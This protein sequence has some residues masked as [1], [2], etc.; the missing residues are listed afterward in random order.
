MTTSIPSLPPH[1]G[2][3]IPQLGL[4]T[5][6][7]DDA[8]VE[9][10][11]VAAAG[12]GYRHVD[13]AAKYG[14]EAA[15][16]AGV[17]PAGSPREEWFVTTKL[18]GGYQG[19]D[20]AVA[21]LD[22]SLER[23]GLD[24]VDLLLI[25]WPLPAARPVR[26]D[27]GDVHPAARGGQGSRDRGLQLQA[28]P[29]RPTD[30]RDRR[31][32]GRQPDPAQPGHPAERTAGVRHRA[33]HRDRVVESHRRQRRPARRTGAEPA[34]R[35]ARPHARSDR[36]PLARAE[37]AGRHP[38]VAQPRADGREPRGLRLRARRRRPRRDRETLDEGP[39]AGVDS[40]HTGH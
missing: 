4:G 28:R 20:R 37:R 11:V 35:Q 2:G 32:P 31:R 25:H 18:D 24:Y 26:L 23:L 19:D 27:L 15:S 7:L 10:A 14:N 22:A 9:R 16:A 12:I 6:P 34:G 21:G 3:S 1:D 40:D 8:E 38:E 30:R 5:W 33:R 13:T 17:P 36:A 29:H 39:D